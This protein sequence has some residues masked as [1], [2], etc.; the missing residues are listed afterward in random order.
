MAKPALILQALTARFHADELRKI[1]SQDGCKRVIASVAF[2]LKDGV[3]SVAPQLKAVANVATFFIGIR[4]DITS[5]QAVKRLLELGVRV[6]AVD[7]ASRSR[8]FHPKLFLA[9]GELNATII[10]GSANMTFSGL[11]NNIEAGAILDLDLTTHEDKDF[12]KNLVKALEEMPSRFPHN[13]FQIKNVSEAEAL[14]DQGRLLDEDVVIAPVVTA[15]VRKGPRDSLKAMK[16]P[17]H[18]PPSRRRIVVKPKQET[19]S[20]ISSAPAPAPAPS[21]KEDGFLLIWESKGLTERDLNIPRRRRTHATGSMLWKKGAA[22]KIDQRHFFRD[23]VFEG[24]DWKTDPSLPHYER[25]EA[26]FEFVIKGVNLGKHTLKLS[27][28]TDTN[29]R[30]Y[31]QRNSMTQV[32]WGRVLQFVA[33]S[34][35]LGRV[36]SLYR[37]DGDPPQYLIEID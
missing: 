20:A 24:L 30:S 14:F 12:L 28:N 19:A 9:E 5:L 37:K 1:L 35:L 22:E 11:H 29:S 3:D 31:K 33:E 36:M 32:H 17:R 23:E 6:F 13:V 16:L 34:D 18:A 4:N 27:H 7:T 2:V 8:I 26:D 25:A 15:S 21:T 10:V